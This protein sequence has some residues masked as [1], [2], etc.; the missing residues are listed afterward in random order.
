MI[1]EKFNYIGPTWAVKSYDQNEQS[2]GST[3][4]ASEW[5][6]DHIDITSHATPPGELV[7]LAE[8]YSRK[9]LPI[10]WIYSDPWG[11]VP[12]ITG[13]SHKEYVERS[14]WFDI[15]KECNFHNL[16]RISNLGPPVFIIGSHCDIIDCD[17]S[18]IEIGHR[19][20][21]KWMA[22]NCNLSNIK[23][24]DNIIDILLPDTRQIQIKHCFANE[25]YLRFLHEND[26][27]QPDSDLH[28][29]L[30]HQWHFWKELEKN[31]FMFEFHPTKMSYVNFAKH[32]REKVI[33]FL[34]I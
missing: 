9:D 12:A 8:K 29:K 11:D 24:T 20:M 17:F 34:N 10:V 1:R 31:H 5:K 2:T 26:S 3:N 6:I 32:I 22:I 23:V 14:D 16:K 21:Q 30:W 25:I 28:E 27:V 19:S 13:M 33:K 15:W 4:F 18:N 7:D